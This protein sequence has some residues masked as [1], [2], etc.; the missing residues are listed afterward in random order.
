MILACC[1][2]FFFV[3]VVMLSRMHLISLMKV[4]VLPATTTTWSLLLPSLLVATIYEDFFVYFFITPN[5]VLLA[6]TWFLISLGCSLE[7][8]G[9]T[10][11]ATLNL[12]G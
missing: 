7:L 5:L 3:L 6:A 9:D 1:P 10:T 8:K 2:F 11:L 4:S 12:A